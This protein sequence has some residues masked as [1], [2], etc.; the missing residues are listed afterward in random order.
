MENGTTGISI[1]MT[2]HGN[3]YKKTTDGTVHQRKSRK[4]EVKDNILNP[5]NIHLNFA[6]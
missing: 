1:N 6:Y 4:R 2:E 3:M 5:I